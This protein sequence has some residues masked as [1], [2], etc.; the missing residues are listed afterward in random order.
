MKLYDAGFGFHPLAVRLLILERGGLS[1]D[2]Q[3]VNLFDFENHKPPYSTEINPGREEV[4]ALVL[5]DGT[6]L[7][8]TVAKFEYLDEIARG[9]E[10]LY[11]M[12]PEERARTRMMLRRGDIELAQPILAWWR[13]D[14]DSIKYYKGTRL[15]IPEARLIQKIQINQNL[16]RWDL[17]LQG[18]QFLCGDRFSA[19]DIFVWGILKLIPDTE[20]V[21]D[22]SRKNFMGWWQNIDEREKSK[23]ALAT[24]PPRVDV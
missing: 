3:Q 6:I 11:G 20:W 1:L 16:N 12:T 21:Y 19:A 13:N 15:P 17:E 8:D 7:T 18:K 22:S 14:P 2:V 4:P 10:S 24:F 23:E 5:H 9:G